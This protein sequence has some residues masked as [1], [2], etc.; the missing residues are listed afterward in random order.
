MLG[1]DNM[2]QIEKQLDLA[3]TA[4]GIANTL[5]SRTITSEVATITG[6]DPLHGDWAT[7][8]TDI[9]SAIT[10]VNTIKSNMYYYP[11]KVND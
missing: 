6:Q 1:H 11:E 2:L 3:I 9:A 4:L 10:A 7:I 5:M 8:S